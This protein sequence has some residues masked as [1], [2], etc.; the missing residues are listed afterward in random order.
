MNELHPSVRILALLGLAIAVQ[1]MQWY[2][3]LVAAIILGVLLLYFHALLFG[4]ILRRAR[5]LL[6]SLLIIYAFTTPGEYL[7]GLPF[8][9]LPTYEGIV[10]GL[11]QITRLTLMLAGLTLLL[12]TTK[13]ESMMAGAYLLLSPLRLLGLAPERFAARLWLTLHYVEQTPL[14]RRQALRHLLENFHTTPEPAQGM[15]K[16]I[17]VLPRFGWCDALVLAVLLG[18]GMMLR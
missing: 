2:M 16:I 17:I 12:V 10:S 13:R 9:I 18:L 7:R 5:W 8:E 15:E 3:L 11:Q 1:G 14:P 6:V 4:N